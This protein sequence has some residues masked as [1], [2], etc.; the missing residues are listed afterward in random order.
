MMAGGDFKGL[1]LLI[2]TRKGAFLLKNDGRRRDWHLEGPF[3]AGSEVNHATLD[4][5]SGTIYATAND[6]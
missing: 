3:L 6:A 4:Q 2:G 5:R 1:L